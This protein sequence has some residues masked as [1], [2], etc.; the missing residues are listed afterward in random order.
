MVTRYS[1]IGN[2]KFET[3]RYTLLE[4]TVGK[5]L[6]WINQT[7]Y[8]EGIPLRVWNFC[9]GGYQIC[10]KWLQ[11]RQ[12]CSLSTDEILQYQRIVVIL[13]E[14]IELIVLIDTFIQ[15]EQFKNQRIFEKLQ[16][17][18]AEHLGLQENQVSL[19]SNFVKNLGAGSLDMLELVVLM[20]KAFDIQIEYEVTKDI[21]IV[22]KLVH[23]ISQNMTS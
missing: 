15:F 14:I 2:N 23:Y 13:D 3:V 17:V 21:V 22:Q 8:F 4:P 11:S 6:V 12:G 10:Q 5:G 19:T 9:L 16:V 1:I 20:E 18:I 7:Q